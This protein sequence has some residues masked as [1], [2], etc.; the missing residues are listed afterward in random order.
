VQKRSFPSLLRFWRNSRQE[1]GEDCGAQKWYPTV[2]ESVGV[3]SR[4]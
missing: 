2:N 4:Y 1:R 3:R